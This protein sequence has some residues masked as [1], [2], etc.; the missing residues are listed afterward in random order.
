MSAAHASSFLSNVQIMVDAALERMDLPPGMPDVIRQ[1]R[2]VVQVRFPVK[3]RGEWRTFNGWRANHSEHM[4]PTKGGIR[5]APYVNQDEVEALASL[6]TFKCAVV[7]VP[8]GG[9]KGG[10]CIDPSEYTVSGLIVSTTLAGTV[11]EPR[12]EVTVTRS[13]DSTPTAA[14]R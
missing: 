1:C 5:Y 14:A 6:M 8:F 10:L 13:P 7:D 11:I 3:L 2:S 4:L 12:R 9:A